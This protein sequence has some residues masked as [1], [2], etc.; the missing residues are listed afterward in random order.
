MRTADSKST[1]SGA[2]FV[3]F[4]LV[5]WSSAPL[6]LEYFTSYIDAWTANGWRYGLAALFWMPLLVVASRRNKL[7]PGLWKAAIVPAIVNCC[8][9]CCFAWAPYY[10]DPGLMTFMLRFQIIFVAFGAYML[11]PAERKVIRNPMYWLGVFAAFGGSLGVCLFGEGMPSGTTAFGILLAI[12]AGI[13]FGG[14]SLSVRYFMSEA[15]S[16]IAFGAISQ[17]TAAGLLIIML[18]VGHNHGLDAWSMT[19]GQFGMLAL[20]ALL[21]IALAHVFYYAAIA[22]LGVAV[23]AG[24]ILLQPFLTGAASYFLFDERLTGLQWL[25]GAAALAGAAVMLRTQHR[26]SKRTHEP[27]RA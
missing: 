18:T 25:C 5:G 6:F 3:A 13:L 12:A 20:S 21:A 15:R 23:A 8:G 1:A 26:V 9:Q 2:A 10:I 11:F 24:M 22:R 16:A 17:Y 14:Y 27:A 4:T 7:P 19:N